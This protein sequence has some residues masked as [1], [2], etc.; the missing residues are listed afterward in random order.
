MKCPVLASVTSGPLA[1]AAGKS[2][3]TALLGTLQLAKT[4]GDEAPITAD[5]SQ[6]DACASNGMP[7]GP[8]KEGVRTSITREN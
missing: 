3:S 4:L 8:T 1:A 5:P 6:I 7:G 2:P